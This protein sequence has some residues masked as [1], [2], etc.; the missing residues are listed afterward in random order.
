M[1]KHATASMQDT[2]TG[3]V[4]SYAAG[5]V[6]SVL[7][8]IVPYLLVVNKLLSGWLLVVTIAELAIIQLLIQLVFFL[9]L[10]KEAKPRWNLIMFLSAVSIILI[11]VIGS[12]WIMSHLNYRMSPKQIDEYIIHDEL[13]KK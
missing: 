11:L 5:F 6:L 8:T 13:I 9:H 2:H 3:S 10:G 7:L 12:V 1:N 4:T